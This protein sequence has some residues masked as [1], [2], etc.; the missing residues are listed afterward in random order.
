MNLEFVLNYGHGHKK[1]DKF[2]SKIF[3]ASNPEEFEL[4]QTQ[5][6]L[7][8]N[9]LVLTCEFP[10][11]KKHETRSSD[12]SPWVCSKI[13]SELKEIFRLDLEQLVTKFQITD[14][15]QA[16]L[17]PGNLDQDTL[18]KT[19]QKSLTKIQKEF[20]ECWATI[21]EQ[22][23]ANGFLDTEKKWES[24]IGEFENLELHNPYKKILKA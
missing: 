18:P 7:G 12:L 14:P 5:D 17:N 24:F 4:L 3:Y 11:K 21:E 15:G 2:D 16:A 8:S 22:L 10:K 23:M 9:D 6:I 1:S 19:L 20:P 13:E